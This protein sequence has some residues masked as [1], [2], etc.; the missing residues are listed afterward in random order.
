MIEN[1]I[2]QLWNVEIL[3]AIMIP[4]SFKSWKPLKRVKQNK[5]K[6]KT[7]SMKFNENYLSF[8]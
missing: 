2:L 5:N 1:N 6:N 7:K 4:K 8:F 3:Q